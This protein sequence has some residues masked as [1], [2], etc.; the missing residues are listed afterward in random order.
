MKGLR[1]SQIADDFPD[2]A[3]LFN[4]STLPVIT[5]RTDDLELIEEM[6]SRL[7]EAAPLNAAEKRNALGGPLPPAAR[8]LSNH[9]FFQDRIP[10]SNSRYRHYDLAAKFLLW[11]HEGKVV[12]VKKVRLDGFAISMKRDPDGQQKIDS[13]KTVANSVLDRMS[14]TFTTADTLLQQV[15]LVSVFFLLYLTDSGPL[16]REAFENFETTRKKNR[17]IA[18]KDL[19][20]ARYDLIEFDQRSQSPNDGS[21]LE[22][23]LKVLRDF[24]AESHEQPV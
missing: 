1:F 6:F 15:G 20:S 17:A 24:L 9:Q 14:E 2:V 16:S 3:A 19:G 21:A 5:I 10:F 11:A 18:E 12:D 8:E 23:R 4:A 7:N 22:L 13:A